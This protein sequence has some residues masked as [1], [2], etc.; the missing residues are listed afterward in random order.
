MVVDTKRTNLHDQYKFY[1]NSVGLI[2]NKDTTMKFSV[3]FL[4]STVIQYY[5]TRLL[6]T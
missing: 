2:L 3:H 4:Y 5:F 6:F 1:I